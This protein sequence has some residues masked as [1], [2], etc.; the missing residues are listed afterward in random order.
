MPAIENRL[1]LDSVNLALKLDL[2]FDKPTIYYTAQ[3]KAYKKVS[4][5][6]ATVKADLRAFFSGYR[7]GEK[8]VRK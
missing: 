4:A 8:L 1:F 5:I 6:P 2:Y 7:T 3:Q